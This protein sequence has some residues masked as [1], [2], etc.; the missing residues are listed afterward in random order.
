MRRLVQLIQSHIRYKIIMPYL[1]L[2]IFVTMAGAAIVLF[3]V[4]ANAQDVLTN[5]LANNAR[6]ISDALVRREQAHVDYL[7]VVALSGA[8]VENNTPAVAAAMAGGNT[9]VVSKT[10]NVFYLNGITNVN[11]DFDRMIAFDR[12]GISLIDWQR[13]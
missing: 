10:L 7:R 3:L 1:A 5:R 2:T 9:D 6:A 4:A 11:L 13:V 8:S 12:R